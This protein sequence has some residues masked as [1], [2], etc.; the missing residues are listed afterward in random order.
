MG[1][2]LKV[3][4]AGYKDGTF[5]PFTC[6]TEKSLTS[7]GERTEKQVRGWLCALHKIG[8]GF[9]G[10]SIVLDT[11]TTKIWRR[12]GWLKRNQY[13]FV[14]TALTGDDESHHLAKKSIMKQEGAKISGERSTSAGPEISCD[15]GFCE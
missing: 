15:M 3:E 8:N 2:H 5:V 10:C 12:Q 14:M 1:Q 7:Y 4:Y 9:D 13:T 6:H 11:I